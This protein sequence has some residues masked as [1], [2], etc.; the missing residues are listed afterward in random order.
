MFVSGFLLV[1]W[2]EQFLKVMIY[3]NNPPNPTSSKHI[4]NVLDEIKNPK[5]M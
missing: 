4:G 2:S 3:T 1:L 5:Q